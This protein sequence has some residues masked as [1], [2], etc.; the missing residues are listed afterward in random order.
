MPDGGTGEA[1]HNLYSEPLGS[2]G[3]VPDLLGGP[4]SDAFGNTA[5]PEVLRQSST[6]TL[7]YR[8]AD[9]LAAQVVADGEALKAVTLEDLPLALYM[10]VVFD[11]LV[12]SPQ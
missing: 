2:P 4:L 3:S 6:V 12:R 7:V 5:G 9:T 10:T 8:V 1:R 11:C